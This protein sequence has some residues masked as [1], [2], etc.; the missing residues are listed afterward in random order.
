MLP[1]YIET[2]ERK[3][4]KNYCTLFFYHKAWKGEERESRHFSTPFL[5]LSFVTSVRAN[6]ANLTKYFF[7]SK[8]KFGW[9]IRIKTNNRRQ[10]DYWNPPSRQPCWVG[11][12]K[13]IWNRTSLFP[14]L[15]FSPFRSFSVSSPFV[16][17][18]HPSYVIFVFFFDAI[19]APY[20]LLQNSPWSL[21]TQTHTHKQTQAYITTWFSLG[22]YK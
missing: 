21:H 18:F 4:T 5:S 3:E 9:E 6:P 20:S 7:R 22:P 14:P 8:L 16:L 15:S 1:I 17:A 10:R 2:D 19:N 12:Y 11:C 13:F